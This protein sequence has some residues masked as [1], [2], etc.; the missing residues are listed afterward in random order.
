MYLVW[1]PCEDAAAPPPA[2]TELFGL[3]DYAS[4]TH[5]LYAALLVLAALF[6]CFRARARRL[7]RRLSRRRSRALSFEQAV[8]RHASL[9]KVKAVFDDMEARHKAETGDYDSDDSAYYR[10]KVLGIQDSK[11][12]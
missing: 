9:S 6:V 4:A 7:L 12:D 1:R 2:D 5:Q 10:V 3:F 8:K 11:K